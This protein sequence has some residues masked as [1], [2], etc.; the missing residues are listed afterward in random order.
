[1][2][3]YKLERLRIWIHELRIHHYEI[4]KTFLHESYK[5]TGIDYKVILDKI[6]DRVKD[7]DVQ[8]GMRALL[9][10]GCCSKIMDSL[11]SGAFLVAFAL[12]LGASN[13][14]VG[15]LAAVS[16]LTQFLQ[17]P[18]IYLV[19]RTASRKALVVLSTFLSR[20]SWLVVAAIPWLV[21]TEQRIPA[22]IICL[23]FYFSLGTISS[24][25]FNPWLRDFVPEE[26][27]GS[28]FGKR[29]AIST[30][31]G[32]AMAL[33]A[34][35][36]L[37]MGKWYV[38]CQFVLYS[39]LFLTGGI[40]GLAAVYFLSQ[41]PESRLAKHRPQDMSEALGQ[42]FRDPNFRRILIFL[43]ILFFAINLS[44]PFYAVYMLK[45]LKLSMALLIGL[46][47]LSQIM[48]VMSFRIWGKTADNFSNKSV[49]IVSGYMYFI[50]VLLWP[51]L[52]L[53]ESYFFMIP[54]LVV[55]H[56]LTGISAAG[57]NLCTT[58]IALKAAPHG[59]ATAFLATN[60]I[61]GGAASA[62]SPILGG[63]IA[64]RLTGQ[65]LLIMRHWLSTEIGSFLALPISS[66]LGLHSLFFLTAIIGLYA[67]HRL[68]AVH[69]KGEVERH[70]VVAHL[71]TEA[72]KAVWHISSAA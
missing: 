15:L 61:V 52:L 60:T 57:V 36:G 40:F 20:I 33:L 47:V 50:G 66:L 8:I 22:L 24:C 70:V 62:A 68:R 12:L 23:F 55:V 5:T 44:G 30:A 18:A 27:M 53:T 10:E 19:E 35:V 38:P 43:G 2:K 21:A 6:G 29:M 16:P 58:N 69:E 25:G 49:L 17:I 63:I 4:H 56:V 48:G 64:N 42:P 9:Y 34:G 13:T 26:I 31:A 37:E 45:Q 28:F 32:A 41:V 46:G 65:E 7:S 59:K 51:F 39:L 1:M 71:L 72:R 67:M 11:T 3:P 14:V 54:L